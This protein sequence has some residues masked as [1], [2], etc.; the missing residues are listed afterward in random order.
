MKKKNKCVV[1][2]AVLIST[3]IFPAARQ[4]TYDVYQKLFTL[5]VT[6]GTSVVSARHIITR[7]SYHNYVSRN[8]FGAILVSGSARCLLRF[9]TQQRRH[10]Y[11]IHVC[12]A[13][14]IDDCAEALCVNGVCVDRVNGYNCDCEPGWMGPACDGKF[15]SSS[16]PPLHP[17]AC[18][19]NP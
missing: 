7:K 6:L 17:C 2:S 19:R 8:G 3:A 5:V 9:L 18:I 1:Y 11:N 12:F 15:T 14:N 10:S 4:H 13:A 16:H